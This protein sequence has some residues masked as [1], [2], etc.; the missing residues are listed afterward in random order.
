VRTL[1][2]N[3]PEVSE[4]FGGPRGNAYP[5]IETCHELYEY[6]LHSETRRDEKLWS[7]GGPGERLPEDNG[8]ESQF[9]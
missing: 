3:L 2:L 4:V 9:S 6:G 5:A 1:D 8:E 7:S